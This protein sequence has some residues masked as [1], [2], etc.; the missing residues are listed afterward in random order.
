[1][2]ETKVNEDK[3]INEIDFDKDKIS[4]VPIDQVH[5][6]SWNP[7][8]KDTEEFR[9]VK[10]SVQRNG[11]KMPVIVREKDGFEIIDGEQRW[12]SAKELGYKNVIIYNEGIVED[13]RAKELTI[14]YQ[15]Q[16]PFNEVDLASLIASLVQTKDV[17]LPYD[18][19]EIDNYLKMTS[20]N[21]DDFKSA[22][23]PDIGEENKILTFSIPVTVEQLSVIESAIDA[24]IKEAGDIT[25]TRAVELIMADYL[26]GK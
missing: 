24:C 20:F 3:V 15:Q 11:L 14:W 2:D 13:N 6:N 23:I 16:V 21:M 4:I 19:E 25:K 26:A 18:Q 8:D 7:K 12:R 9:R 1:M 5:P 22:P 10:A 17:V